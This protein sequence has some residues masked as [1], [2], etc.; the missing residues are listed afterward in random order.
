MD[1]LTLTAELAAKSRKNRAILAY[2]RDQA[3]R[4]Q[5]LGLTVFKIH[6]ALNQEEDRTSRQTHLITSLLSAQMS[7]KNKTNLRSCLISTP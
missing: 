3:H 4:S 7:L 1:Q 5:I 2:Q 6:S